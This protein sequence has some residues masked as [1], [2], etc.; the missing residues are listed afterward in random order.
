MFRV[1]VDLFRYVDQCTVYRGLFSESDFIAHSGK[2][3]EPGL[4]FELD[5]VLELLEAH[6]AEH[7]DAPLSLFSRA[8]YSVHQALIVDAMS[9]AEHVTQ[10]VRHDVTCS[11]E[12]IPRLIRVFYSIQLWIEPEE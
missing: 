6:W 1:F 2:L 10:L 4:C 5:V 8:V 7:P 3:S 11:H 12:R 9:E